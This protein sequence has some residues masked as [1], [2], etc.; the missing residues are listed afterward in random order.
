MKFP[1]KSQF[2]STINKIE[3][4]FLRQCK[5]GRQLNGL[6]LTK[7]SAC[8]QFLDNPSEAIANSDFWTQRG[9]H[10][11]SAALSTLSKLH[12]NGPD[13]SDEKKVIR[14]LLNYV[15]DRKI[16]ENSGKLDSIESDE[17]NTIKVSEFIIA[18]SALPTSMRNQIDQKFEDP[19]RAGRLVNGWAYSISHNSTQ[20]EP[21][22]NDPSA[23]PTCYAIKALS[24][25]GKINN[26][27]ICISWIVNWIK[28]EISKNN[29]IAELSVITNCIYLLKTS[30]SNILTAK[31]TL[32][33][34][35]SW[36]KVRDQLLPYTMSFFETNV[37]YIINGSS[38][39]LRIPFQI[40]AFTLN[41][42][43]NRPSFRSLGWIRFESMM[44]DVLSDI[45]NDRAFHYPLSSIRISSRTYAI[46]YSISN[47]CLD[48]EPSF[49]IRI[50]GVLHNVI[51]TIALN[52]KVVCVIASAIFIY[53][54]FQL[55]YLPN[56]QWANFCTGVLATLYI[57]SLQKN[58]NR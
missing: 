9:F 3:T 21:R 48:T 50:L 10:G 11:C 7:Y 6:D 1:N 55:Y 39:Y 14:N 41:R 2:E 36:T 56:G 24:L 51:L 52:K 8:G 37:E 54:I 12:S 34:D 28:G 30:R 43:C 4:L 25:C 20:H 17:I 23:L 44:Y 45:V 27:D 18:T 32:D 42:I 53:S 35:A 38:V 5:N 31:V 16:A 29:S 46:I 47:V 49:A 40:Y 58:S 15:L 19:L 22:S 26:D 13:S 57:I 33:L